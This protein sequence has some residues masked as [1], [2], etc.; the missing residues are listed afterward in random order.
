MSRISLMLLVV[1]S[2]VVS[3]IVSTIGS[4]KVGESH[5][6]VLLN[7]REGSVCAITSIGSICWGF[8]TPSCTESQVECQ[9]NEHHSEAGPTFGI[10]YLCPLQDYLY[11][12]RL[13]WAVL[14]CTPVDGTDLSFPLGQW[15]PST[16][17]TI[18]WEYFTVRC[19]DTDVCDAAGC[20]D[21]LGTQR[22][23]HD[24]MLEDPNSNDVLYPES[25]GDGVPCYFDLLVGDEL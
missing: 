7:T 20:E 22:C 24:W 9:F 4:I 8:S 5:S 16:Y 15:Y 13:R 23:W 19:F 12:T 17:C 10:H 21:E 1:L 18:P 6:S 2:L 11:I 3:Q 25:Y 14:T